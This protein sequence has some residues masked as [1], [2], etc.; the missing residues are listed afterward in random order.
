MALD[1]EV[2][3]KQDIKPSVPTPQH[4]KKYS[5]SF[6]DHIA[7]RVFIPLIFYYTAID[8]D[9]NN[10]K[11][12]HLKKS[13]SE[14]LTKF[15][16]LASRF[17]DNAH[18]YCNDDGAHYVEARVDCNLKDIIRDP[19]PNELIK[20]LPLEVD[21]AAVDESLLGAVIS[22]KLADGLSCVNFM[23][24]WAPIARG[25]PNVPSPILD[26]VKLFPPLDI[27]GFEDRIGILKEN[28]ICKRFVFDATKDMTQ[29][30]RFE[31]VLT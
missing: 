16:P 23:T 8:K 19:I 5:I 26:L 29:P 9:K 28:I 17:I 3:S 15:Y 22:H 11:F 24:T 7:P 6:L 25:E 10:L 14:A 27:S 12:D 31:A 18:V 30:T 21:D 20:L 1:I 4:L 13:L 2:L